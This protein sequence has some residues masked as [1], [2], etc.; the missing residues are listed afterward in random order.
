MK[1]VGENWENTPCS[2]CTLDEDSYGTKPYFE[3]CTE[4]SSRDD[5]PDD[6]SWSRDRADD[7]CPQPY[8]NID[9]EDEDP[10]LPLSTLVSAMSLWI[11]LSLPAR[12]SIQLRMNNL[13]YSEI[14][15]RLGISRQAAEKAIAQAISREPLLGNLLPSKQPRDSSPLTVTHKSAVADVIRRSGC[16]KKKSK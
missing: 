11:N 9:G 1:H 14:G 15:E 13:P 7:Q 12:K 3:D 4:N 8:D 2:K 6:E 10:S 16:R 5:N